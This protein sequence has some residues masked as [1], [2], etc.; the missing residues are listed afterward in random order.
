MT[1]FMYAL[2]PRMACM[3]IYLDF[4]LQLPLFFAPSIAR[5]HTHAFWDSSGTIILDDKR[6]FPLYLKLFIYTNDQVWKAYSWT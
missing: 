5:V 4:T 1:V 2:S 3:F 6:M